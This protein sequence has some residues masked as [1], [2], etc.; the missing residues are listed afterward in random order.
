MG[1]R[2]AARHLARFGAVRVRR[3]TKVYWR[4]S[5]KPTTHTARGVNRQSTLGP[6][7][8]EVAVD[9]AIGMEVMLTALE[10]ARGFGVAGDRPLDRLRA[11]L[12]LPECATLAVDAGALRAAFKQVRELRNRYLHG[13]DEPRASAEVLAA[14][15]AT[16]AGAHRLMRALPELAQGW[17]DVRAGIGPD[18]DEAVWEFIGQ[19]EYVAQQVRSAYSGRRFAGLS[20]ALRVSRD[21]HGNLLVLHGPITASSEI[22]QGFYNFRGEHSRLIELPDVHAEVGIVSPPPDTERTR[23]GETV[24]DGTIE[25]V[26]RDIE[27][28][29][30]T[31]F[32]SADDSL[33]P[34]IYLYDNDS[35]TFA[36]GPGDAWFA[37]LKLRIPY[38]AR[39]RWYVTPEPRQHLYTEFEATEAIGSV[40]GEITFRLRGHEARPA[41]RGRAVIRGTTTGAQLGHQMAEREIFEDDASPDTLG[42]FAWKG[43]TRIAFWCS[44]HFDL[45]FDAF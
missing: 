35:G 13:G 28:R 20:G 27:A 4:L 32:H 39:T 14:L 29:F 15:R 2:E 44:L 12:T 21:S 17:E 23:S 36:Y 43:V 8:A 45:I 9:A 16:L 30:D 40:V 26:V 25:V 6:L 11:V 22:E 37:S 10:R 1:R 38:R 19:P 42:G 3:A 18:L 34:K 41:V 7:L 24:V 33:Y 5:E 31:P